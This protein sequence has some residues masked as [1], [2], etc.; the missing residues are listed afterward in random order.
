MS[1][2]F[3]LTEVGVKTEIAKDVTLAVVE[4]SIFN[5]F[6]GTGAN[7]PIKTQDETGNIKGLADIRLRANLRSGGVKG[8]ADFDTNRGTL[9]NLYQRVALD[10]F[11][12]SVESG[13]A[14]KISNQVKFISFREDAK[15]GLTESETDKMDRIILSR[16]C[17]DAT[18]IVPAGH[19]GEINTSSIKT[20]DYLTVADVEEAVSVAKSAKDAQGNPKPKIT[21]YKTIMSTDMHGVKVKRKIYLMF[22][23]EAS[24]YNLKQDPRW[25]EKQKAAADI[26]INSTLFTGQLGVIDDCILIELNTV[27]DEYAGIYTSSDTGFDGQDFSVYEGASSAETEINVLMGATAMVMPMDDGFNYYEEKYDM[28]RKARVGIDRNMAI[29]KAKFVGKTPA[30]IASPYHNKDF[31]VLILPASSAKNQG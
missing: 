24:A 19:R 23:G 2:L 5:Q 18:C 13:E 9:L 6:M 31:G 11:G 21:P 26:G 8:N 14:I 25:E 22:V 7:A 17:A 12:N 27:T 29:E 15:D 4:D 1:G 20:T 28:D 3:S 30:E 16:A 10:T